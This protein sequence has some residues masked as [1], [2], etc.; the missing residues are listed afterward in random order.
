MQVAVVVGKK[1]A[2]DVAGAQ[3]RCAGGGCGG[4]GRMAVR[5]QAQAQEKEFV[6]VSPKIALLGMLQFTI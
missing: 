1:Y 5:P 3:R 6:Y 2:T 4:Q